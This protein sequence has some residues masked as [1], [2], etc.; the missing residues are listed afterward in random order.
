[1][2]LHGLSDCT[3]K[4]RELRWRL[5]AFERYKPKAEALDKKWLIGKKGAAFMEL[6]DVSFLG[7]HYES[8]LWWEAIG[9]PD[10]R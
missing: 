5:E 6:H 1:M 3:I 4:R 9:R 8:T 2:P 10:W 7:L